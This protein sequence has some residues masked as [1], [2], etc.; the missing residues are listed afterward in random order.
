MVN[1]LGN[2]HL[3]PRHPV[4]TTGP[5]MELVHALIMTPE[6]NV[7]LRNVQLVIFITQ[8]SVT[9]VAHA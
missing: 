1:R 7:V 2:V 8:G 3:N 4:A 6:L 5:A 9:V